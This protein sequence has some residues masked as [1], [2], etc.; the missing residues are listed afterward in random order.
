MICQ[1]AIIWLQMI[2]GALKHAAKSNMK[3]WSW[4]WGLSSVQF[5]PHMQAAKQ[6]HEHACNFAGG[7]RNQLLRAASRVHRHLH[8][9]AR[10]HRQELVHVLLRRCR[11]VGRPHHR[12]CH[13]VLHLQPLPA[14][15][16]AHHLPCLLQSLPCNC[17]CSRIF[18]VAKAYCLFAQ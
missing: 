7:V 14:C 6:G 11:P 3:E 10:P 16:G 8:R 4:C 5:E 18:T 1:G 13:R 17:F 15:P 2:R 9:R 12:H